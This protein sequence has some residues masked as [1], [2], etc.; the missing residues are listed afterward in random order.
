MQAVKE[1]CGSRMIPSPLAL[2]QENWSAGFPERMVVLL[3]G[4]VLVWLQLPG[5]A[6]SE[7]L[8]LTQDERDRIDRA[9]NLGVQYL[10]RTQ[11]LF[12]TWS[13]D[14]EAEHAV[15][16]AALPGLAL[17]EAGVPAK[18][19]EIQK[20]AD[21]LRNYY[22]KDRP[23]DD[24]HLEYRRQTYDLSLAILF[25]DR[26][27]DPKDRKL[28]EELAV[29]LMAGQT[30]SGG[31]S[32]RCPLF[33]DKQHQQILTALRQPRAALPRL[34][35][36][37][38]TLPMFRQAAKLLVEDPPDKRQTI[39]GTTDNSNTQFAILA[40]WR[41]RK[42]NLPMER[43]LQLMVQRFDRSQNKDGTWHYNYIHGGTRDG[44]KTPGPMTCVGL[45]GLAVGHGIMNEPTVA[46]TE[47]AAALGLPGA[48][49]ALPSGLLTAFKI[50]EAARAKTKVK[51]DPKI[52]NGFVALGKLIDGPKGEFHQI[53][54][55]DFYYLW[56]VERVA[57]LYG[58]GSI[59]DKDWYR[60]GVEILLDHQFPDG[61]WQVPKDGN[62]DDPYVPI[63]TAFALLFLKQV[64]LARDLTVLLPF[65][66]KAMAREI[67]AEMPTPMEPSA[68]SKA[69]SPEDGPP[70]YIKTATPYHPSQVTR[71]T[72]A[73]TIP[74]V[75]PQPSAEEEP[76]N[77]LKWFLGGTALVVA[78]SLLVGGTVLV[79]KHVEERKRNKERN[80]RMRRARKARARASG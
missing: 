35:A 60:W 17:L 66:P 48:R 12:G 69:L 7:P 76:T 56:S 68:A 6:R 54:K 32:Y 34:P 79:T 80:V 24:Q 58:L 62:K 9:V 64:N 65:D 71:I 30:A 57:A 3:L 42:Y 25:L 26:L 1:A 44:G 72:V 40:L 33:S 74:P 8:P 19:Q 52:L 16:F 73:E 36:A 53:E 43:T 46:A 45:L 21:F 37:L 15:G 38:A 22:Q 29:R 28:I 63:N 70:Q 49:P 5:L 78:L 18:F 4:V 27:G 55:N 2:S 51:L 50:D 67:R 14:I 11:G 39:W 75:I 61:H 47:I 13:A 59:G 41:A 77:F 10:R 20:V 23:V 31:W